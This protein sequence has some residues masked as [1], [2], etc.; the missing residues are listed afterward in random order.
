MKK[1]NFTM[2]CVICLI[3]SAAIPS[4]LLLFI[5]LATR[6]NSSHASVQYLVIVWDSIMDSV[7][8]LQIQI[9]L[10]FVIFTEFVLNSIYSR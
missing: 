4:G 8:L 1:Q 2:F 10:A 3:N 6:D 5:L 9:K 7:F